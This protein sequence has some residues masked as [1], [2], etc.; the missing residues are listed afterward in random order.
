M[1]SFVLTNFCVL[2]IIGL[3]A[4]I[5]AQKF[6]LIQFSLLM[7]ANMLLFL[8]SLISWLIVKKQIHERPQAFVRGIYSA[9]FLKLIICMGSFL[10]YALLNREHLYKPSIF[11]LFSIYVIYTVVETVMLSKMARRR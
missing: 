8:L 7:G 4:Y 9:T 3:I 5:V 6:P 1:K 11:L 2:V 10:A